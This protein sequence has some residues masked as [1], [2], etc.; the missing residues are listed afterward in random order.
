MALVGNTNEER[1]WNF[2][3]T[4]G[5][6]E[7]G[8]AGL[9]GNLFAESGLNPKNLQNSYEKKL[10]HN[11]ENYTAAVDNGTYTNFVRDA[12]G[13]GLA[14]WTYWS[15]KQNLLN[16]ARSKGKS[17][18]DLECQLDF[19][20]N[21]LSTG[22]KG[23][24]EVLKSAETVKE[25]SECVMTKFE[26]P[27]DQSQTAKDKRTTYG[28]SYFEKYANA[29]P[30]QNGS[31]PTSIMVG[32]ARID[33]NGKISG[34]KA[35]DQTGKEVCIQPYYMSS[36]GW[37]MYRPINPAE[38]NAIAKAMRD[39]C[40][41]DN[42]GYDQGQRATVIEQLK[43]YGSM[44]AIATKTEG[45]CSS[46]VRGCCIEAGFDP[47]NFN[48]ASEPGALEKTGRFEKK[49]SVTGS[50]VL[51]DGDILVTK[52]KGHTVVVT[53]GNPRSG[54]TTKPEVKPVASAKPQIP[55]YIVGKTYTAQVELN[56]RKTPGT[57]G[58]KVGYAGLTSNAKANDRN[59]NGAIDKGTKVT[60]QEVR[61]IGEDI[62]IKIPSGWIAAY[63][64]GKIYVK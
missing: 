42:I 38:A 49:V 25:A 2:L 50:T 58:G 1:I 34:G 21:E 57:S 37:Y 29:K 52:T 48:T 4:K 61:Q 35:G 40:A 11:D 64:Q 20:Y 24:L 9:M 17:V 3:K 28:Q 31:T 44:K 27:A 46:L 63:Y 22:Y 32:S 59:K 51:H 43:K 13:Y 19:L 56:V 6:S 47:G 10:G 54:G 14:Q 12:A 33:E 18:G 15:R 8:I 39:A 5:L 62:W 55:T 23:V 30:V 53:S 26:R 60:C 7:C 16:Y 45:D 36:K 41:N